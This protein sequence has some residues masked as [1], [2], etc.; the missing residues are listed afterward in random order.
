[1]RKRAG[2]KLSL[3]RGPDHD[4]RIREVLQES[5]RSSVYKVYDNVI[6]AKKKRK[7][8]CCELPAL[9]LLM[10]YYVVCDY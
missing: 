3:I 6:Y 9:Y 10:L 8:R 5:N 4:R 1:M 7:L 2:M